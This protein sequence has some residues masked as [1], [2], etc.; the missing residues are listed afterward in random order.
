MLPDTWNIEFAQDFHIT[1]DRHLFNQARIGLP[2]YEGKMIQ[3][4]DAFYGSPQYLG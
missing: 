1:N 2:L 4:F 3:Q